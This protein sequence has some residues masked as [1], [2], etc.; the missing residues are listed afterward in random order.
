MS[1]FPQLLAYNEGLGKTTEDVALISSVP[2]WS[3]KEIHQWYFL[4]FVFSLYFI[5]E[6]LS[7]SIIS[8]LFFTSMFIYMGM[9]IRY[10]FEACTCE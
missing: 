3:M 9:Y 6:P 2:R 10:R 1:A 8:N 5:R 7:V 4:L